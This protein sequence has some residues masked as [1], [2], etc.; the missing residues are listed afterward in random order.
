MTQGMNYAELQAVVATLQ[1]L[2]GRSLGGAWQSEPHRMILDVGGDLLLLVAKGE[3]RLHTVPSRPKNPQ[4][5]YSFQGA[6]RARLQGRLE[7]LILH[8]DRVIDLEFTRGSLHFRLTGKSSG[9]WLIDDQRVIAAIDGPAPNTLPPLPRPNPQPAAARF[10]VTDDADADASAFFRG[11]ER[12]ARR[13][14]AIRLISRDL[15]MR[16]ARAERLCSRLETDLARSERSDSLRER[17]DILAAHL[18]EI[19]RGASQVQFP[20]P[21]NE[22]EQRIIVLDP[23]RSAQD[24]MARLYRKATR[25]KRAADQITER[26]VKAT[27]ELER[28]REE[29]AIVE[30]VPE[31]QL[32][33]RL[34]QL[35][36]T[37]GKSAQSR[38]PWYTWRGPKGERVLVGANEAG[39]RQLTFQHARGHD[40]WMH[41]RGRP[42]AHV[43]VR[44]QK[45]QEPDTP[46]LLAGAQIVLAHAKIPNGEAADVQWTRGRHVRSIPGSDGAKVQVLDER[47]LHLQRDP[48]A[49][50]QWERSR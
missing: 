14:L 10:A 28:L 43:V 4:K 11:R 31:R 8:D 5:P 7:T 6:C 49:L 9:L 34:K 12:E 50:E 13:T 17:A 41:L 15:K 24:S 3:C 18:H 19:P 20:D 45:G 30:T 22:G 29:H 40:V 33:K 26:W 42:G 36:K 25:L 48:G 27:E 44:L 2:V 35:Q 47:V 32:F 46:V 39:N 37:T 1:R 38:A 21:Y 23:A 16:L